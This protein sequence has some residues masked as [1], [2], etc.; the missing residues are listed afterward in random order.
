MEERETILKLHQN[1]E[2]GVVGIESIKDKINRDVIE[3]IANACPNDVRQ[4]I[5]TINIPRDM[6]IEDGEIVENPEGKE[7]G[8]Y[9]K[10]ILANSNGKTLFIDVTSLIDIYTASEED[11]P[12]DLTINDRIIKAGIKSGS[13]TID[14]L[15]PE[16]INEIFEKSKEYTDSIKEKFK[17]NV[18]NGTL[19]IEYPE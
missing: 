1:V 6:V 2:M 7:K 12:I 8:T 4:I 19:S 14:M 16:T 17:I 5:G 9:I 10:L 11:S 15:K 3:Y 18:E 13:I